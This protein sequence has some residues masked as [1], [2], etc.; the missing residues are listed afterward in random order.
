MIEF[1]LERVLAGW[2]NVTV[3][4]SLDDI[5]YVVEVDGTEHS[6]G[7]FRLEQL[8]KLYECAHFEIPTD[9]HPLSG[10]YSIKEFVDE[11]EIEI[12]SDSVRTDYAELE[13]T[14]ARF[15][16]DVFSELDE[17]STHSER[18]EAVSHLTNTELLMDF[19]DLEDQISEA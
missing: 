8:I 5:E 13:A 10:G 12:N 6:G 14:L 9:E 18:E 3:G 2:W 16:A 17:I 15:L 19:D 1:T 4:R 11:V 7:L